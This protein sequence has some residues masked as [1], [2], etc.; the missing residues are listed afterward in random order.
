MRNY[1][2]AVARHDPPMAARFRQQINALTTPAVVAD[3]YARYQN[4]L[5]SIATANAQHDFRLRLAFRAQLTAL[6]AAPGFLAS[7]PGCSPIAN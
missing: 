4:L 1:A 2:A 5:A 6:C 3:V 7:F